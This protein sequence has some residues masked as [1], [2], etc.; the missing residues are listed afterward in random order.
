MDPKQ[1]TK[2]MMDF[3]KTVFD[4]TFI[5]IMTMQNQTENVAVGLLEKSQW[6]PEEGKKNIS[7]WLK[8][9]KKACD[10]FRVAADENYK[11]ALDYITTIEKDAAPKAAKK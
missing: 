6:I 8:T 11:K 2:Q 4:N 10:D 3:N 7:A 1:I 9:Y 5:A